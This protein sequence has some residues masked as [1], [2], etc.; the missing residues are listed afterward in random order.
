M[1][2]YE[3]V[4][5]DLYYPPLK[6]GMLFAYFWGD[7]EAYQTATLLCHLTAIVLSTTTRL[8]VLLTSPP[9]YH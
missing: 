6:L 2:I 1:Y 7:C 9:P 5:V 3:R 4:T 8:Y